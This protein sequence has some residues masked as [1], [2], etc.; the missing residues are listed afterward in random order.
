MM[1]DGS[2]ARMSGGDS[3]AASLLVERDGGVGR[4][5][6]KGSHRYT[7]RGHVAD[8]ADEITESAMEELEESGD[9]NAGGFMLFSRVKAGQEVDDQKGK[10]IIIIII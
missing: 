4:Q 8:D 2:I 1:S 6:V 5:L 3:F 7:G 9:K 10:N